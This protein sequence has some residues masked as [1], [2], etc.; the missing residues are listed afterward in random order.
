[1]II[2]E[3]RQQVLHELRREPGITIPQL[4]ERLDVSTGTIRNDIEALENEGRLRRVRGGAI[5]TPDWEPVSSRSSGS[6]VFQSRILHN[7]SAKQSIAAEVA[8]TIQDGDS[9]LLDASST[10]FHL[11]QYLVRKKNLRIITNC[12]ESARILARNPTHT[13]MLVGGILRPDAESTI[14]PWADQF[15]ESLYP[16]YAFFS[17][18]G[19]TPETGMFEVDIFEAQY[20]WK[21]IQ[22]AG[23][24]IALVDSSKFGEVDLTPSIPARQISRL[25]TDPD[26]TIDWRNRLQAASIPFTICSKDPI[27][28]LIKEKI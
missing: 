11:N 15:L 6:L 20:R 13:V 16:R 26:L 18:S 4:A 5:L 23:Q 7:T 22:S 3:R 28:T 27:P 17:C 14:G 25:Y 1:M 2:Y 21:A 12:L 9:I 24:V 8:M 10:V 19:F